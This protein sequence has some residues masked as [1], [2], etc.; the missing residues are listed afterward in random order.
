[1]RTPHPPLPDRPPGGYF[2]ESDEELAALLTGGAEAESTRAV[3]L[4]TARHWR[5][6]YDYAVICL[7]TSSRV[8]SMVT[9]AAFHHVLDGLTEGEQPF[10]LRPRLLVAVRD[11]VRNWAADDRICEALPALRKPAG[12]RGMRAAK[13]MTAENRK[14]AEYAFLGLPGAARCLLWHT[15]VEAESLSVPAGLLGLD[16]ES[17]AAAWDQGR[18]QFRQ[19][20]LRAHRELAPTR[21]CGFHNRLLD[22]SIRRGGALLPE[23]RQHLSECS[24]CRHAAA[25]LGHFEGELGML[26]AESVLGWGAR[27]YFDSR[28]ARGRQALRARSVSPFG[29]RRQRGAA[30]FL[31]GGRGADPDVPGPGGPAADGP[32]PSTGA[33]ATGRFR[34]AA[35][36]GAEDARRFEDAER[37]GAEEHFGTET[38][39]GDGLLENGVHPGD[40]GQPGGLGHTGDMGHPGG[41]FPGGAGLPGVPGQPGGLGHPGEGHP[42]GLGLSGDMGHPGGG[43]PGGAG[44]P[45]VPGQ[46]GGLGHTGDV[47][48]PGSGLP[49]GAGLPGVPGESGGLGHTG[50]VG[51]P[52]SGLPGGAGLP[53]VP[54]ESGGLGQPGDV[55]YPG[56][57]LP[58]GAGLPGVP[59]QPKGLS[60][61]GDV[62]HPGEGHPGGAGRPEGVGFSGGSGH[63]GD[64]EVVEGA[65]FPDGEGGLGGERGPVGE[66]RSPGESRATGRGRAGSG[67]RRAQAAPFAATGR[68][69]ARPAEGNQQALVTGAGL[70]AALLATVLAVSLWPNEEGGTDPAAAIGASSSRTLAP[71]Q[72]V[73]APSVNST[74]PPAAGAP[75]RLRNVDAGLCLDVRG[76][77]AVEGAEATL[78]A[79]SSAGTQQWAYEK[80][81]LLRSVAAP[82]LCLDARAD[83]GVLLLGRC[84][85][86]DAKQR[87]NMQYDF[88]DEGEV[89][90][91]GRDG[92]AVAPASTDPGADIVVKVR[93]YSGIQR[94]RSE[95][96]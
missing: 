50:D 7:A 93:D 80:D 64:A 77:R 73:Q 48:Y 88:T 27:R 79:C 35:R 26:I 8:A 21:E 45:G 59:G 76:S 68:R 41:G 39:A 69:A 96:P 46:S 1:M 60:H 74:Q 53:G 63:P 2:G 24:Y 78:D 65:G 30:R 3:A 38:R 29:G 18:E 82:A 56:S 22:A 47:G 70:S 20:C 61:P 43:F 85:E 5:P 67:R 90:S 32:R 71:G 33:T 51:Y 62:G 42:G 15:E 9:E 55:G 54:G 19:A 36:P 52:G 87:E 49:G 13:S 31:G 44:L 66:G 86:E 89:L 14:L 10:A 92:L 58:G 25:Q 34:S 37:F 11:T 75:A 95:R 72:D 40:P 94:W 84:A 28:R 83:D 16:A 4:L 23:V 91:R 17:A 57:G 6:A 12:G 81:G